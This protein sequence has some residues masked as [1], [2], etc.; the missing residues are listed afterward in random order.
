MG[1]GTNNGGICS[2]IHTSVDSNTHMPCMVD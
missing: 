2:Y 1:V